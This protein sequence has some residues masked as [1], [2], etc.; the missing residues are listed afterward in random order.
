MAIFV[1]RFRLT[2]EQT[3]QIVSFFFKSLF[4]FWLLLSAL[5]FFMPGFAIRYLNLN[6]I[7]LVTVLLFFMGIIL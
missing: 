6:Y 5:D 2:A 7:L 1:M 3:K 4:I